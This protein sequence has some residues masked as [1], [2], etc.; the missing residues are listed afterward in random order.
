MRTWPWPPPPSFHT[1]PRSGWAAARPGSW[2]TSWSCSPAVGSVVGPVPPCNP[3][4]SCWAPFLLRTNRLRLARARFGSP[5]G[6]DWSVRREINVRWACGADSAPLR[7]GLWMTEA[8][9]AVWARGRGARLTTV[10][11]GASRGGSAHWLLPQ[12]KEED[13]LFHLN[14]MSEQNS[15]FLIV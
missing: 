11:R 1:L 3:H 4:Q 5:R 14:I 10:N 2:W 6:L 15:V 9:R 7:S 8:A 12:T 13:K